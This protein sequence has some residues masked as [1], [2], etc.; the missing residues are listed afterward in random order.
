MHP[1]LMREVIRQRTIERQEE[2]RKGSLARAARKALRQRGRTETPDTI[3]MPAIPDYV[4]GTFRAAETG[5]TQVA[6]GR[7]DR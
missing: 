1:D 7:S 3:V 4:D 2:A 6:A 5:E